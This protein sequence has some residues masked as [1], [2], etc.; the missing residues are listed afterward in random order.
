MVARA[1]ELFLDGTHGTVEQICDKLKQEFAGAKQLGHMDEDVPK[2][3]RENFYRLIKQ[4]R[5]TGLL[6]LVPPLDTSLRDQIATHFAH[7][8]ED[9]TVVETL[10][11]E[12]NALV[13]TRAAEIVLDLLKK[14]HT[15]KGL[16]PETGHV[17]IGLGPGRGTFDFCLELGS[18]LRS[19]P[20]NFRLG[21][22]AISAGA[23]AYQPEYAS[24]S[25]YNLFPPGR[26]AKKVGLFAETLVPASALQRSHDRIQDR[27]GISEAFAEIDNI[28][29][30]VTSM[31]DL[32]DPHDLLGNFLDKARKK[33]LPINHELREY[34]AH[35]ETMM[36]RG[37]WP[38]QES[39]TIGSVQY[40]PY[41]D[42]GPIIEKGKELRACTLF[43]LRDFE[44]M[45]RGGKQVILIARQCGNCGL[46]RARALLPLL[47]VPELKVWSHI[48]MD[49][50]T[51][52]ELLANRERAA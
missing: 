21:L 1:A 44:K 26:V 2:L 24:S 51:A 37:K 32:Q 28:S 15:S 4:A 41:N 34:L 29:V 14:L 6:R 46:T 18:L 48:V 22:V 49:I 19:D 3:I 27:P 38:D 8:S 16:D 45:V 12:S 30:V 11:K 31:G 50:A 10:G 43:E 5:D 39:K 47:R 17:T 40:R 13:A 33:D 9:F 52:K 25:F 20:S 7:S 23:P 36:D 35:R 42:K